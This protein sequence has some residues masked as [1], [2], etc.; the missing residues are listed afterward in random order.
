MALTI[1]LVDD[2]ADDRDLMSDALN[3]LVVKPAYKYLSCSAE[4]L[5]FLDTIPYWDL[6]LLIV[7]DLNMPLL[8]GIEVTRFIKQTYRYSH[9]PVAIFSGTESAA[10][11]DR[12]ITAGA[13]HI[14]KKPDNCR[15]LITIA[16]TLYTLAFV[17]QVN[18]VA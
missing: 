16:E 11:K 7:L 13:N 4:V 10:D 6:P 9:I 3:S 17:Q 18:S 1:L 15:D 12:C 2:D 8:N 14:F 5:P